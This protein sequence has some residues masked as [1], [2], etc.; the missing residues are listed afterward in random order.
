MENGPP[1][2]DV[3]NRLIKVMLDK[4]KC[5]IY[6]EQKEYHF[7][8]LLMVNCSTFGCE[9]YGYDKL[10]GFQKVNYDDIITID[11]LFPEEEEEREEQL[12]KVR[13][14]LKNKME[15]SL[16]ESDLDEL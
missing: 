11:I 13:K 5:I 3:V 1:F 4:E 9:I 14:V 2:I 8:Q 15:D 12:N 7:N 10:Y 16:T 6:T